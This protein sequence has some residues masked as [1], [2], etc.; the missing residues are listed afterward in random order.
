MSLESLI[1][2]VAEYSE[3]RLIE[4]V[5]AC[6]PDYPS[7]EP[8]VYPLKGYLLPHGDW[9]R[10][11]ALVDEWYR[12]M[13]ETEITANNIHWEAWQDMKPQISKPTPKPRPKEGWIYILEGG[14]YYKIGQ[15]VNVDSR[16]EQFTPKLPFTTKL[17]HCFITTDMDHWEKKLHVRFADKRTNGEWFKLDEADLEWLKSL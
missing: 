12:S 16:L 13:N 3:K 2:V 6:T 5:L 17:F 10:I 8:F 1:E 9:Q 15:A 14:G 11:K 7:I 4:I